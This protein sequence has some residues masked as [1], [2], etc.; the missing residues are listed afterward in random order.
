MAISTPL[1]RP[2]ALSQI[3]RTEYH[4]RSIITKK[5]DFPSQ[6]AAIAPLLHSPSPE[7]PIRP[8]AR[9]GHSHSPAAQSSPAIVHPLSPLPLPPAFLKPPRPAAQATRFVARA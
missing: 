1:E 6:P 9:S 2:L 8:A 7:T 5:V 4:H 3:N